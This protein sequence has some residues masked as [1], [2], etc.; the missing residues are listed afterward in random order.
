MDLQEIVRYGRGSDDSNLL[1]ELVAMGG[2]SQTQQIGITAFDVNV[3]IF[4]LL[5][6]AVNDPE[7]PKN[8]RRHCLNY[9]HEPMFQLTKLAANQKQLNLAKIAFMTIITN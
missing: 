1:S 2:E 8:W 9:L 3:K 6:D 4:T 5:L 7:V